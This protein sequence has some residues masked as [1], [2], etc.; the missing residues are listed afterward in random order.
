LLPSSSSLAVKVISMEGNWNLKSMNF[1]IRRC[2]SLLLLI[3]VFAALPF[4]HLST[5]LSLCDQN[6]YIGLNLI[7]WIEVCLLCFAINN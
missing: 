5:T 3:V 2:C 6:Q 7:S 1:V 4:V